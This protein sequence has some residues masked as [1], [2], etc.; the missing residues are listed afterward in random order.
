MTLSVVLT[1][2][3]MAQL[4]DPTSRRITA[5][6]ERVHDVANL[7]WVARWIPALLT[8][9]FVL[10]GSFKEVGALAALPVDATL[11]LAVVVGGLVVWEMLW[12]PI[13]RAVHVAV[14]GF[15]LLLPAAFFTAATPYGEDKALRLF[16]ITF[17]SMLAPALL[18]RDRADVRRHLIALAAVA[19]VVVGGGLFNPR[20]SS[21]YAGAPITTESVDTIGL[22][23][24]AAV[25]V[26]IMTMA[27]IWKAWPLLLT[28]PV[29]AASMYVL[30]QSG[31][32]G[33]LFS[34]VIAVVVGTF[35]V[36]V[37]PSLRRG[38]V[39][40]SLV[41][42]GVLVSFSL[43]PEYSRGRILNFF[44][45]NNSGS[46]DNR[47]RLIE[48]GID[49]ITR[50]PFG[51]GLGGFEGAAFGGYFYPHDLPVEVLAEAGV[52]LGGAFLVWIG[53]CAV[54]AH[55]AS[56]D[57]TGGTAFA[58]LVCVIGKSLV[59]GDLNDNRLTF[60][61]LGVGLAAGLLVAR[62]ALETAAQPLRRSTAESPE[63]NGA[64]IPA[65]AGSPRNDYTRGPRHDASMPTT[66]QG[67]V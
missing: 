35:L 56:V 5:R 10:S 6:G 3:T 38:L 18:I 65:P 2:P 26:V 48:V 53:Y 44:E 32:R 50:H 13:P 29:G 60:Y 27:L 51:I 14:F 55:F 57:F 25:V 39:V 33:P 61:V 15:L 36:R 1:R 52:I 20:L 21:N 22:G 34:A 19:G 31:S 42:V 11:L 23:T 24:A 45:G 67:R 16:T 66:G 28:L 62:S 46:V 41:A 54:R 4:G 9:A 7:D 30:L 17:L 49:Q 40:L 12:R 43:A 8:A 47:V 59:S 37:R 63:R 58:V 64:P